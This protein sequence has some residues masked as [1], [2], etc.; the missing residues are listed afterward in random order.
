MISFILTLRRLLKSVARAVKQPVFGSLVTTL[1]L[2]LLSGTMFYQ[3]TESWSWLDSFYFSFV[4][5]IP[6]GVD[7]G[8]SPETAF[9]KWF[10]MIYLVVGSGVMLMLILL[11]GRALIHF[12]EE[13][14]NETVKKKKQDL[15]SKTKR[16]LP[17]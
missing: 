15:G 13:V 14:P 7:T 10:T 1:A 4:S 16:E 3:K 11:L 12:D 5:L 9:G 6:T 8:M 2:I 17:L